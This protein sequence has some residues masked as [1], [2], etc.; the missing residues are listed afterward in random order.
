METNNLFPLLNIIHNK[1]SLS[2]IVKYI[3][4]FSR[5]KRKV[6]KREARNSNKV[7]VY[8]KLEKFF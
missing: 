4:K 2:Y 5:N 7:N 3:L 1:Y 6:K 8:E